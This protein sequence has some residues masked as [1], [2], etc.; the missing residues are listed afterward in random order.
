MKRDMNLIRHLLAFVEEQPAGA[1]IQQ[2]SVRCTSEA[3]SASS[4]VG[5]GLMS[6]VFHCFYRIKRRLAVKSMSKSSANRSHPAT[7]PP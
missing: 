4:R 3:N 2:V 6:G 7:A 1:V 5:S